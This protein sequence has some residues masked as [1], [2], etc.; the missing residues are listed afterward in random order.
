MS[1]ERFVRWQT[2]TIAQ[3]SGAF[4]LF[5][6]LSIGGLGFTFSLLGRENFVPVGCYAVAFLLSMVCFFVASACSVAATVTRLLDFRLTAQ[7]VRNDDGF[8]PI[9]FFGTDANGYGRATWRLFWVMLATFSIGVLLLGAVIA[10]AYLCGFIN[11][12]GF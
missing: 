7:K 1:S 2:Q 8:E 12:A 6:A 3:L 5:A 10:N 9:T 11:A 4:S